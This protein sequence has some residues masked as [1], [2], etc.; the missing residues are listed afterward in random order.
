M[1]Y[2]TRT[3]AILVGPEGEPAPPATTMQPLTEEALLD[4]LQS[5]D[6][7][8]RRLPLGFKE[9]ARA[10]ERAHGIGGTKP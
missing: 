8:A 6:E 3:M 5:V 9:F 1:P 4:L 10:I 7:T 2:E